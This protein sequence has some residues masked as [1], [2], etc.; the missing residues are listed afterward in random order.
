MR[1]KTQLSLF[2]AG[3]IG[4]TIL[5]G[6]LIVWGGS[7]LV[8]SFS[9]TL[10]DME[11]LSQMR[12]L[13]VLLTRQKSSL[14]AYFL[15]GDEQELERFDELSRLVTGR[16]EELLAQVGKDPAYVAIVGQYDK[17]LSLA[18]SVISLFQNQQRSRAMNQAMDDLLPTFK[19]FFTNV[20]TLA[21]QK[22]V[23]VKSSYQR[24]AR[25]ARVGG[26][27][28]IGLGVLGTLIA[29]LFAVITLRSLMR[30]LRTLQDGTAEFGKGR[31][32][33][34]IPVTSKNELGELAHSFNEMANSIKQLEVQ[35]VH[36]HRMSAV[37][38][39]AGGVAHEINNPLTGVLGQA[40]LL[41]EKLT[42]DD[43][44]RSHI[45][46]IERA[47]VR[48]KKIVRSLLDFSRQKETPTTL[49]DINSIVEATLDLCEPDFQSAH[50]AVIKNLNGALQKISGHSSQLQQVFL[51]LA[52]NAIQAME[53]GGTLTVT[54]KNK[55]ID[56][57]GKEEDFIEISF[58]DTGMG[59][60]QN[61]LIHV[62]E[63]FFTT[64]EIGKGTGLGLSVSLGIIQNH[65]GDILAESGGVGKG[66][67]FRVV[68]PVR[69]QQFMTA[70]N[71]APSADSAE[72]TPTIKTR[73][74]T[75]A[76]THH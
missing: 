32:D 13:Q 28:A 49:V 52:T 8:N 11:R 33:Y 25:L 53:N 76:N 26:R 6:V 66:A 24:I 63:P 14:D 68:L 2:S 75:V 40:Q 36:M 47:A 62:F 69:F 31:W 16:F 42:Q 73:F 58:E 45:E 27:I 54:T 38:Q 46:K 12:S 71:S 56:T 70:D 19:S 43:P 37:G 64:K 35:T 41:L 30:S 1:I 39:L 9:N 44:R 59:I 20:N 7:V 51:N 29:F 10:S 21:D 72:G 5:L 61:H 4:I 34:R 50:V 15:L 67:A 23:E 65:G 18:R 3:T 55:R 74:A 17:V 57:G 48:C 60:E 22:A